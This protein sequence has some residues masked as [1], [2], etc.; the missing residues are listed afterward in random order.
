MKKH[1]KIILSISLSILVFIIFTISA[2]EPQVVKAVAASDTVVI[3]LTVTQQITITS[4]ADSSMSTALGLAQNTAVGT[5]T[6]N[7]KTND[8]L[9]YTM[10]LNAT[11]TPAMQTVTGT[12]YSILD[13]QTGAPNTW[14]ATSGSAYFG[15]SAFGS[16]TP[17]GTWGTGAACGDAVNTINTTLKYQG[18]KTTAGTNISSRS[19]TTTSAGTDTNVCYAVEQKSFFIPAATYVATVVA[20]ATGN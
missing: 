2:F 8:A 3:T 20:T 18:L 16:D 6:W 10:A 11:T 15:Y 9:G 4:P 17:T 12:L 5:T 1:I 13:Y 7:V 14:N 19:A